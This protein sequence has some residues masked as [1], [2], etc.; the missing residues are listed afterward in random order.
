MYLIF[1]KLCASSPCNRKHN[2]HAD[3]EADL[4]AIRGRHI[5]TVGFYLDRAGVI[6]GRASQLLEFNKRDGSD[7]S[8]GGSSEFD[9]P[10]KRAA[11]SDVARS[12]PI[13][14]LASNHKRIPE[15]D[16]L[17]HIIY[18]F[19]FPVYTIRFFLIFFFK[20][21]PEI[22]ANHQNEEIYKKLTYTKK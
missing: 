4:W 7:G 1:A 13:V 14:G 8:G 2:P 12:W 19:L 9:S 15:I 17:D 22:N 6:G 3:R 10:Q 20:S 11:K 5:L 16:F 18:F 21:I